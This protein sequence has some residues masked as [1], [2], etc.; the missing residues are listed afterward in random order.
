MAR[1]DFDKDIN[2]TP[3]E[4]PIDFKLFG[5]TWDCADDVNGKRLLDNAALLDS[6]SV[7]DQRDGVI[8]VFTDVIVEDQIEEFLEQLNDPKTRIQLSVLV[9]IVGWL[10]DQYTERPTEQPAP[11]Q[12]GRGSRGRTSTAKQPARVSRST[13]S[14]RV[15]T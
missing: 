8:A 5:Q 3:R 13:R 7:A 11:S 1:R 14:A 10:V 15:T 9:E 2:T 4:E 12:N 6:E